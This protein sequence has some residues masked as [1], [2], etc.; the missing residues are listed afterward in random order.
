[1]KNIAII[2][3]TI[4]AL[5]ACKKDKDEDPITTPPPVNEEEVITSVKITFVNQLNQD[6]R[7]WLSSDPDGDG[8]NPPVIT[9]D[10]L[11]AGALYLITTEFFNETVNPAENITE[12]VEEEGTEHQIF[13]Q[14]AAS[15]NMTIV[16]NDTDANGN[17]I[18]LHCAAT[19]SAAS[20]GN[21]TVVL[22]HLPNKTAAGVAQGDITNAN[23]DT[24]ATV[25]FDVVIE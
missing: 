18:G 25:T 19:T 22:R 5:S 14:I 12:E 15:L 23:G 8:S 16:Y 7:V 1:M 2:A 13:Y 4:F 20:S 17:P 21:V 6:E 10:P 9:A 11:Q 24:D 3:L